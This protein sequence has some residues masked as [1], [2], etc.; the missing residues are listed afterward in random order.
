MNISLE[1]IR[2]NPELLLKGVFFQHVAVFKCHLGG[3][4]I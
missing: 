3:D 1:S 2:T 4:S